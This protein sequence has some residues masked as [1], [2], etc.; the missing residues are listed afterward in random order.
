MWHC[1][2]HNQKGNQ[3]KAKA[4]VRKPDV[5]PIPFVQALHRKRKDA[6][7]HTTGNDQQHRYEQASG[8]HENNSW[9]ATRNEEVYGAELLKLFGKEPTTG[10]LN[11]ATRNAFC[12]QE[13][14]HCKLTLSLPTGTRAIPE[15]LNT[16]EFL[17]SKY[18]C[19]VH[20]WDLWLPV[21]CHKSVL[22]LL[23]IRQLRVAVAS[24]SW[25]VIDRGY[26]AAQAGKE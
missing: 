15:P 21:V 11:R 18:F 7:E 5:L 13:P 8:L 20:S 19:I 1:A 4:G 23:H 24:Q 12:F 14:V 10:S 22:L 9:C 3:Q 17:M 25:I 6:G 26:E 2:P 16:T